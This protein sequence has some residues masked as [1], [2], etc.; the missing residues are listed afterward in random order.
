MDCGKLG[1]ISCVGPDGKTYP[2]P[3][4]D[5]SDDDP[6]AELRSSAAFERE[7]LALA[8]DTAVEEAE[9]DI[10]AATNYGYDRY[11]KRGN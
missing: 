9:D 6:A 7:M 11:A 8:S 3:A 4:N 1:H 2:V 5:A 10:Q